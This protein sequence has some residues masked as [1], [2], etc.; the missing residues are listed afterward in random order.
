MADFDKNMILPDVP[1][2]HFALRTLSESCLKDTVFKTNVTSKFHKKKQNSKM[3][4]LT[5]QSKI[6]TYLNMMLSKLTHFELL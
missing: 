4:I 5:P 6:A 1:C 2:C 3:S